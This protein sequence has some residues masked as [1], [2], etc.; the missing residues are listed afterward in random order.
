MSKL[1]ILPSEPRVYVLALENAACIFPKLKSLKTATSV[2]TGKIRGDE[3][4]LDETYN[5]TITWKSRGK[6]A[7]EITGKW[8]KK[9]TSDDETFIFSHP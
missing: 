6:R 2:N 3:A 9:F 7:R 8:S 4:N 5:I 1:V